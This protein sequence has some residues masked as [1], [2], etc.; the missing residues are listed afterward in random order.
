MLEARTKRYVMKEVKDGVICCIAEYEDKSSWKPEDSNSND[1]TFDDDLWERNFPPL[2]PSSASRGRRVLIQRGV[3][4]SETMAP[5]S[6]QQANLGALTTGE[7]NA[8]CTCGDVHGF[9]NA[10]HICG[11]DVHLSS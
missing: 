2:Q 6:Q 8:S 7:E 10:V 1:P 11:G 4:R 9:S 3:S 5:T